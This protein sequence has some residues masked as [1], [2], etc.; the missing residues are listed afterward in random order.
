MDKTKVTKWLRILNDASYNKA[1]V[2]SAM[3]QE[4]NYDELEQIYRKSSS[5]LKGL[6]SLS[7]LKR[8]SYDLLFENNVR[9]RRD[10]KEFIGVIAYIVKRN[11]T[12]INNYIAYK[13]EV[14]KDILTG[15]YAQARLLIDTINQEIS[16]SYWAATSLIKITRLEKGLNECTDFYNNLCEKDNGITRQIYYCAYKSSSLDF[17]VEDLKKILVPEGKEYTDF[18]NNFLISHSMPYWEF[19]E[20]EWIC[21]DT[22]SSLI[23]LYNIFLA[24]LPCLS[25]ATINDTAVRYYLKELNA[26]VNDPYLSKICFLY[27]ITDKPITDAERCAITDAYLKNEY[28]NVVKLAPTYLENHIDD[29]E[30]QSY[31]LKSQFQLGGVIDSPE[32]DSSLIEKIKYYYFSIISHSEDQSINKRRLLNLCRSQYHLQGIRQ[33]YTMVE[34][35]ESHDIYNLFA[36]V[37]KHSCYNSPVDV[38][39]YADNNIRLEYINQL[40]PHNDFWNQIFDLNN[41]AYSKELFEITLA[42]V[43]GD[44]VFNLLVERWGE[45]EIAPYHRDAV[46][47]YIFDQYLRREQYSEGVCFYVDNMLTDRALSIGIRESESLD[48]LYNNKALS[49]LI[50]LELSIFAEMTGADADA[51]YFIYK[52]YLKQ[53]GVSKASEIKIDGSAKQR[54]F[55]T[56][57]A[58]PKVLNLHVLRFKSVRQVMEERSAICTNLYERFQDK[59]MNEEI[60]AICRDIKIRELNNQVDD[61][62]IFVDVQ[63]LKD[64][65]LE[66]AKTLYD[67]FATANNQ[68]AY[69]EIVFGELMTILASQGVSSKYYTIDEDGQLKESESPVE[70]VNYRKDVLQRIFYS[71][72]D[73]FLFNPKYGLDNYLSTRIRHGTLINQLRNHFEVRN[74]VT[75]TTDGAYSINEYWINSQLRL[76]NNEALKC[77]KLFETFSK[78]IDDIIAE[79]K[80]SF[81]QVKTEGDTTKE[82]GCFDFD[83]RYFVN[84]IDDLLTKNTINT[85]DSCFYAIIDCLWK[86]TG[87]CLETMHEKL[88]ET[89]S[90]M[91]GLLHSLQKDVIDVVG[92][93][94]EKVNDFKDAIS[95][96]QNE[97]Q[98][99]FQIV[100]KWFK[101]SDY[102]DFD[103]T[104]GQVIDTS[105]AFIRRN[106]TYMPSPQVSINSASVLQGRY[107]GPLYDIFH[108]ILNNA[109][110]YEKKHRMKEK[111]IIDVREDDGYMVIVVSNPIRKEDIES[112]KKKVTEINESLDEKLYKGKS[113][114]EGNSGCSKIFNAV[115]YH[116]GSDNN[117]YRN[118]IDENESRFVVQVIIELKPIKK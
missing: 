92:D 38:V 83:K 110:D 63:S 61:S 60:S 56:N 29:F 103:F 113:R 75:N 115:C 114:D 86:R 87:K 109:L 5:L 68:V 84:D 105:I 98:N 116:L 26:S 69:R 80:D 47:T 19:K 18:V 64:H 97:I 100:K 79:I 53:S 21:A 48:I 13:A 40:T 28:T 85:F 16:Y 24:Y 70:L 89:Q 27:R 49:E 76:R 73:Q 51:I 57:V 32:K 43:Q 17:I 99:D 31:F 25:E 22:N 45:N 8:K 34:G 6:L 102:V 4:C 106:N 118:E 3:L 9:P 82:I 104:I 41:T 72:R 74:L 42:S 10:F 54:Y 66:E 55:L 96:C 108:D 111:W 101:R 12:P 67:M 77:I 46:A 20:G 1:M 39:F 107:F 95:Y 93:S 71:I 90:R 94:N 58:V 112:S 91:I 65:E 36:N 78:G 30:I 35:I 11:A 23:D 7:F 33:L 59:R 37:W 50:P 44:V 62:K 2:L 88:N 15:Q 81:I 14:E 117:F 52:R